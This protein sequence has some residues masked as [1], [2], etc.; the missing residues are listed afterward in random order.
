MT[1]DGAG[2]AL[3]AGAC[4]GAANAALALELSTNAHTQHTTIRRIHKGTK[5]RSPRE[6][7]D[8]ESNVRREGSAGPTKTCR[9]GPTIR[10][11]IRARATLGGPSASDSA[12]MCGALGAPCATFIGR[13][14]LFRKRTPPAKTVCSLRRHHVSVELRL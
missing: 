7:R 11:R 9:P 8:M 4:S 6:I 2:A 3:S 12:G 10:T 13:S 5:A 1:I 14:S